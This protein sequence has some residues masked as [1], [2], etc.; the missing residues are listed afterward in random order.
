MKAKGRAALGLQ[1]Q[2]VFAAGFQ[3]A[4]GADDVG[5][6]EFAR[7]VDGAVNVRLGGQVHDN[8]R[9]KVVQ[10]RAHGRLIADILAG[11]AVAG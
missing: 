3:Q 2:P 1:A 5:L 7:P 4:V 6:D 8:I 11:K 9:L 10:Q